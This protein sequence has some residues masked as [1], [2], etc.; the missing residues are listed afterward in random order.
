S[1]GLKRADIALATGCS[2]PAIGFHL[3]TDAELFGRVRRPAPRRSSSRT[4]TEELTREF[5]L[6]F[7]PGELVVHV[8][9]G[10]A[11]FSGMRLIDSEGAH[12]EYLELEYADGDKLFVPVENL[13]RV[14]K[15]L[16]GEGQPTLHRLGT[17]DWSRARTRAKK[18]V[19]DV[20]EDLL[21]I[22]SQREARPGIAFAPDTAWQQEL[23]SSFP[24]EETPDQLNALAEIKA[25][26]ESDR[27]MDRLLCG[28][29]GFGKTE[30]ALRAAF[31][32]AVDGKQVAILV[33]TTVL[34]QQHY[35][36]FTERLKPFPLRVEVLSRFRSEEESAGVLAG[37]ADGTVDIV[38]GTH[39]L[40]SPRLK[41]KDLGVLIVD[42]EQRFG[43]A[44]KEQ[45]KRMRASLDVLS[46]S[47]TPI[48]RT[49]H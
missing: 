38:I 12:R 30:L 15:Y 39:R 25:D 44:Q 49:L 31:K 11:R 20:A 36:T 42:E 47:A 35:M 21:K 3:L 23:E 19:Q 43:V 32:A 41:F 8:D 9:H 1:G 14:Q 34:A 10:I 40:L 26:M 27:P 16:G 46:M 22:Y 48:P 4:K 24:Y 2:Q 28:D 18:V 37:L 17:G 13:D 33:P 45:L 7:A 29:V 6:E 5:T